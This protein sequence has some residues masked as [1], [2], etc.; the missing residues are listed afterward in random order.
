MADKMHLLLFGLVGDA[1]FASQLLALVFGG[2]I[3]HKK[4]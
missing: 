1:L 4:Q 3:S 2:I